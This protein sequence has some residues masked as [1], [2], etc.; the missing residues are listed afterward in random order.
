[1]VIVIKV[2]I[3]NRICSTNLAKKIINFKPKYSLKKA[4]E[5]TIKENRIF[6][7]GNNQK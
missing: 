6:K 3:H 7:I 5:E 2:E 4:I 1:M